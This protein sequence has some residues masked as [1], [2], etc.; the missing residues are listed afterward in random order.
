MILYLDFNV[1]SLMLSQHAQELQKLD[2][3]HRH[4]IQTSS[5]EI[6]PPELRA[7]NLQSLSVLLS[8]A[9]TRLTNIHK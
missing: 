8:T 5:G 6:M 9:M 2:T 3:R 1:L 7:Y 4:C